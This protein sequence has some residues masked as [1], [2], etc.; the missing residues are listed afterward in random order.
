MEYNNEAKLKE[1]NSNRLTDSKKGLA[2][3]KGEGWG[4]VGAEG[5]RRRLRGTMIGTHGGGGDTGKTVAQRRQIVTLW[6]LTILLGSDCNGVWGDTTWVS[7]TTLF[8]HVT[9]L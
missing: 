7:V 5:G 1:Q 2:V 8:F 9:P 6:H 4:R 3:T